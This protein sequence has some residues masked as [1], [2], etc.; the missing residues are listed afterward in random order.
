MSEPARY[1]YH[2]CM[3][4]L[5]NEPD[6]LATWFSHHTLP[7]NRPSN[8]ASQS[9][10]GRTRHVIHKHFKRT[11]REIAARGPRMDPREKRILRRILR[12]MQSPIEA[13]EQDRRG[14]RFRN[15]ETLPAIV[16][17]CRVEVL[18]YEP[19][20]NSAL[21]AANAAENQ[22]PR[23]LINYLQP[24]D[25]A[26]ENLQMREATN[27]T[28]QEAEVQ[29]QGNL[30]TLEGAGHLLV[31]DTYAE[32]QEE[33]EAQNNY[34]LPTLGGVQN[35]NNDNLH[36]MTNLDQGGETNFLEEELEDVFGRFIRNLL[37]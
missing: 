35:Q 21:A 29:Q 20:I 4:D 7:R 9:R 36:W 6:L 27:N 11:V 26:E 33:Q 3:R 22:E 14:I 15:R 5:A 13:F 25:I 10:T 2:Y 31:R 28:Q 17:R 34:D 23:E 1:V 37:W 18:Y 12:F 32:Q 8:P 30:T 24:E 19:L 16:E